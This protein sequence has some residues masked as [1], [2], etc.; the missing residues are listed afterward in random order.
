[1]MLMCALT[2]WTVMVENLSSR[3]PKPF[4]GADGRGL[5]PPLPPK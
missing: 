1:M 3:D 4:T 5:C 2:S